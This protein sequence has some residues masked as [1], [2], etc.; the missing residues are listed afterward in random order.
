MTGALQTVDTGRLGVYGLIG[1]GRALAD[2]GNRAGAATALEKAR[3]L[4]T[5]EEIPRVA[6]A[7]AAI[8][9]QKTASELAD[10]PGALARAA[11]LPP[12]ERA[13][14]L[15]TVAEGMLRRANPTRWPT[16]TVKDLLR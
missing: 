4:A 3:Q 16:P 13:Q 8:G 5:A 12:P 1:V 11:T 14:A 6:E 15:V 7:Y 9:D 10:V 2:A